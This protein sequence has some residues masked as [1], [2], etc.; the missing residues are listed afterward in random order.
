MKVRTMFLKPKR[1]I[2]RRNRS[3]FGDI[4]GEGDLDLRGNVQG[5]IEVDTL[6]IGRKGSVTGHVIAETVRVM[7]HFKGSI[8]ARQVIVEKGAH[9]EGEL[10]YEQLSVAPKADLAAKLTPR[11]LLKLLQVRPPIIEVLQG[12]RAVA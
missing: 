12:L 7:G 1:A 4:K 2:L 10:S 3:I 9:V 6:T 8:Q 5:D 11:P